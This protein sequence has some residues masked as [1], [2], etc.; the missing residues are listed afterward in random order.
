TV[1]EPGIR[2]EIVDRN[3][4]V[5]AKN[6]RKYEVWFNL[7]E[8]RAAYVARMRRS[9]S[10]GERVEA[11]KDIVEI[12]KAGEESP[13]RQLDKLQLATNFNA[14]AM[15]THEKTH[16]GLIP[17]IYRSD[18]SFKDFATIAERNRDMPGVS[19][20]IRPERSYPYGSLASH[21]LG[22][23]KQWEKGDIPPDGQKSH[24]HYVGDDRGIAGIEASMDELLRGA[25]GMKTVAKDEKGRTLRLIDYTRPGMGA[26]VM[27]TLD[28][29]TQYLVENVLRRTGRAAA[30]V[31]D[32]R[33]GEVIAMASVPDY[34]PGAFIP[35]IDPQRWKAYCENNQLSPLKNRAISAYAPGSTMKVPTALTGTMNGLAASRLSCEGYVAYGDHKVGCWLWNQKGGSHGTLSLPQALQRSCNPYF[36]KLANALGS[37]RLVEGCEVLGLGRRTGIPLPAEDTGILPGNRAWRATNPGVTMTPVLAAFISI[38]QG[39]MMATPLQM[40]SIAACVANGGRYYQPRIVRKVVAADG[41]VLVPDAPTLKMDLIQSGVKPEEIELVRR[42]MWMAVNEQGGTAS[43]VRMTVTKPGPG[44]KP[45]VTGIEV[46]AKT[47]TAQ[48]IDNGQKSHNSWMISFAPYQEP[49]YAVCVMVQNGG[50]GGAVCG[51]LSYLIYRGLFA[52]DNV[53]LPLKAQQEFAGNTERIDAIEL[54]EDVL[55][56]IDATVTE[57]VGETGSEVELAPTPAHP[58]PTHGPALPIPSFTP[59]VDPEGT[60]VPRAVPVTDP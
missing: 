50:S 32:V 8:I 34:E 57:D 16:G 30:V 12:V 39:D 1:R 59:Q 37:Q 21:V 3:G 47:G 33:T 36:N 17:Y 35:S 15:R 4:V 53:K 6:T 28:A 26:T 55:A 5:L 44:G 43:K 7:E 58:A 60:V 11:E 27:L 2:G 49:R 9:R 38:G 19:V 24:H 48:T 20:G 14:A 45:Q 40:C 52:D 13:I 25:A 46:A 22:Y 54:P 42:G 29:R 18:L 41:R 51:P 31:M 10:S 23:L 56:A